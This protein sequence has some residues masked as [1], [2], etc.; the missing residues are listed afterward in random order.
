MISVV[1]PVYNIEKYIGKCLESIV[2]QDYRD[3]EIILV[4]DG[5][6]DNSKDVVL[7]Y[8]KDKDVRYVLVEKENGGLSSARNAGLKKAEGEYVV[9]IDGDDYIS[10]D[11][12]SVLHRMIEDYDTDFSFC[13]FS[14]I[15]KQDV[16]EVSDGREV[17]YTKDE[18]L[19][20]FLKRTI[21]FVVPSMMFTREFLLVNNLFFNENT[22]FSE[23][24]MFIWNVILASDRSIYSFRKM[25]GYYVRDNSIMT[26][27]SY[28][29]V[30]NSLNDYI[31]YTEKLIK[32]HPEYADIINKIL[33]RWQLGTLYTSARLL[34]KDDY[35][36]LYE[37]I[38]GR[39]LLRRI[40]GIG[41]IKAYL[42]ACVSA[43]SG[44]LLYE[45][46]RRMDLNG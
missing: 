5:S 37:R 27:S 42:L 31:D 8:L 29:K 14:F 28:D 24:Q 44:R 23:D 34:N 16:F 41:E 13:N 6:K 46:C 15:R 35:L 3:F 21:G 10:S 17:V 22:R 20:I 36:K 9:F 39:S 1:I 4:N 12:L 7:E 18:L 38:D 11:F 32:L 30:E 26:S 40:K 2:N 25:Y 33:P 19:K 45:L 43:V